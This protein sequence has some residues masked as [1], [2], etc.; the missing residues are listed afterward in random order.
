MYLAEKTAAK[1]I[2]VNCADPGVV[3]TNMITMDRWFDS[4]A[5]VIARP[6]MSSPAVG[7]SSTI[8]ALSSEHSGMIFKHT[9]MPASIA[10][11]LRRCDTPLRQAL[12]TA[13]HSL[14]GLPE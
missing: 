13:T 10:G 11:D 7:A 2:L 3:D 14:L 4:L 8:S 6:F 5:N 9:H 12:I 1:D